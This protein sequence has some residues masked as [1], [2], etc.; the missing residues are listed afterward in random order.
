MK[1]TLILIE[2]FMIDETPLIK[3]IIGFLI[4]FIY[5]ELLQLNKPY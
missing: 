1:M 3:G 5:L 4:M 2:V